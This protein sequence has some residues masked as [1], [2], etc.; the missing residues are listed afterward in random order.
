MS[1]GGSP[2]NAL[3]PVP[4]AKETDTHLDRDVRYNFDVDKHFPETG[5]ECGEHSTQIVV[6]MTLAHHMSSKATHHDTCL[7]TYTAQKRAKSVV[8]WG[9][10]RCN[11]NN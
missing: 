9:V 2:A 3:N 10:C 4:P 11:R 5:R 1:V 6:A 7:S 8:D